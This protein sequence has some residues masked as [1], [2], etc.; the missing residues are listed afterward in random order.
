[1]L[2]F[3]DFF[4]Q[5][6]PAFW[7]GTVIT[8]QLTVGGIALGLLVGFLVA[9]LRLS[10]HR[11]LGAIAYVYALLIRGTPLLVQ[12]YIV[13]F[14]INLESRLAS[15]IIALGVN[16][17]AYLSEIIRAAIESIDKGQMEAARSLGMSHGL[18]MRRIIIPQTYKRLIPP[19]NNEFIAMLKDTSLVSIMALAELTRQGA[20]IA[21]R[22]FRTEVYFQVALIYL[23]LTSVFA[24]L[25]TYLERRAGVHER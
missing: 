2:R 13:Y 14:V 25:G 1:M 23:V 8:V 21:N 20:V 11:L 24:A 19:V 5:N 18:A 22:T 17:G 6:L 7:R 10:G 9:L 12:I 16:Y 3:V 15:G 4:A